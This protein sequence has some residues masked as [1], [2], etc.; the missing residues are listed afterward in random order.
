MGVFY[1]AGELALEGSW[2]GSWE[3]ALS[4]SFYEINCYFSALPVKH[5]W[6]LVQIKK[7]A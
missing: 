4:A 1:L 6:C 2:E 5:N 3:A 7:N